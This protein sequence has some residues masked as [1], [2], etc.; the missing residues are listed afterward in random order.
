M[1]QDQVNKTVV[2]G[3]TVGI[4]VLF[5]TM[6]QHFLMALFL[7]G[8]FSALANPLFARLTALFNGRRGL[9]SLATLSI[10]AVVVLIPLIMLSGVLISQTIDVSRSAA[11]WFQETI[12]QPGAVSEL[13]HRLPFYEQVSPY[14]GKL[15]QQAGDAAAALSSVLV[16]GLSSVA[17]GA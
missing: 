9:A 5:L 2:L 3:L 10:M 4:S 14:W 7:A 8:I 16:E 15:A 12:N 6:V 17:L 13:L 1:N 11:V